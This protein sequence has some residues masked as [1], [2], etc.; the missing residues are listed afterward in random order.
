MPDPQRLL[1]TLRRASAAFQATPGRTGHFTRLPEGDEVFVVGDMHGNVE[2]MRLVLEKAQLAAHPRRRLVVQELVHGPFAY[3][4]SAGGG[5]K[6]HQLLDLV[7]AL[8]C[9]YPERVHY[10]LGN[11]ELAQWRHQAIGKG[12]IEQNGWFDRGVHTAY[13][14]AADEILRAYEDLFAAADL[15]LRTANRVFLCHTVPPAKVDCTIAKLEAD[16]LDEA[17][18]KSGGAI[19]GILW[20]R[21]LRPAT[22]DAFLAKVDADWL[23]TGHIPCPEG[24]AT[25]NDR[26]IVLDAL[27]HPAC[28]CL[29]P[30]DA[31]VTQESLLER[32][33]TL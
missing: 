7:A 21:D 15:A 30:T 5:D 28:Y 9:Q 20:G 31:A 10:L 14:T 23:I 8:K 16:S 25:P 13:G 11:H 2:N 1:S 24:F 32:I 29:F 3:S 22:V 4:E 26:Q 12:D 33:G 18:Y 27:G 17:E 19:H 6:S